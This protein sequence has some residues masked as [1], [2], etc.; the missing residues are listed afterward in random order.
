[1]FLSDATRE[2]DPARSAGLK[3]RLVERPGHPAACAT[4]HP[5]HRDFLDLLP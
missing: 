4:E 1:L 5:V 2:L 3:T